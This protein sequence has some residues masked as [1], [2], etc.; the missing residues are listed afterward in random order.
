M[1]REAALRVR[2]HGEDVTSY[3]VLNELKRYHTEVEMT[4]KGI[5]QIMKYAFWARPLGQLRNPMTNG[6]L[7]TYEV[8]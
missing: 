2:G 6:M 5:E 1:V 8:L 3:S 4:R 7:R